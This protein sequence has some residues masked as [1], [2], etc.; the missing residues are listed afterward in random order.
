MVSLA[1][2]ICHKDAPQVTARVNYVTGLVAVATAVGCPVGYV[3][4]VVTIAVY[5]RKVAVGKLIAVATALRSSPLA[6]IVVGPRMLARI[7]Q[8][9][10]FRPLIV[11]R[12]DLSRL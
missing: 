5:N 1:A 2:C 4:T 11:R 6:S 10:L 9:R 8:A 3:L 7:R 12:M